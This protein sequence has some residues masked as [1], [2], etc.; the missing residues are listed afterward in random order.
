MSRRLRPLLLAAAAASS[1]VL[2]APAWA[3]EGDGDAAFKAIYTREWTWRRAELAGEVGEDD[4]DRI[5]DHL[6]K[7]DPAAQKARLDYWTGVMAEVSRIDPA[8]L[9][10]EARINHQIYREQIQVLI[11]QQ[12]FRDYE[13][14][15]NGDSAFWSDLTSESRESFRDVAEYERYIRQM[16]DFPRYFHDQVANMRA[17]PPSPRS[18]APR[19]KPIPT[20]GP[21][22]PCRPASPPPTRPACAPRAWPLSRPR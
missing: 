5:T 2:A 10:P 4:T 18:P 17:T 7:I 11:N 20:T 6:P 3:A 8:T 22:R 19:A 1:L 16:R 13:K 14:P 12:K 21:S 9:S 15:L